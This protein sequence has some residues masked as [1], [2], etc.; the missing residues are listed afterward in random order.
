ME[1]LASMVAPMI[2]KVTG[3]C[4]LSENSAIICVNL[5]LKSVWW[6]VSGQKLHPNCA[7][8]TRAFGVVPTPFGWMMYWM[9]GWMKTVG[10]RLMM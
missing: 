8:M 2:A 7:P 9:S 1:G 4:L 3:S 6:F 5:R 10:V